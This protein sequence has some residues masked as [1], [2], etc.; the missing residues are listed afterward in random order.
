MRTLALAAFSA[1]FA[2]TALDAARGDVVT[3]NTVKD[4]TLFESA[5]GAKADGGWFSFY[6]GR[7]GTNSTTPI[8]R[9]LIAFDVAGAVPAGST[10]TNVTLKLYMSKTTSGAKPV[11]LYRL[12]TDWSEGTTTGQSGQGGNSQPGDVTWIHTN[13][14]NSFWTTPGGDFVSTISATQ[15][16]AGGGFYTWGSTPQMVADVQGWLDAPA[17]SFGWLLRSVETVGQKSA[18][19]FEARQSTNPLW[20]PALQI[21][22][23]PPAPTV[24]CTPKVDSAGCVP[25]IGYSGTPDANAGSGF[26]ITLGNTLNQ[27]SGLLF[28][29]THGATSAPFQGGTMCVNPPT[30]R[31]PIQNSGGNATPPDD[32]SGV[33]ALDFNVRIASGVDPALVAGATVWSQ[34]WSR[35]PV[36]PFTTNLSDALRF[37]IQP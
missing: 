15:S 23:T 2:T 4:S 33:F 24:Y 21:T 26:S 30:V 34:F 22:Y 8:R 28:Y 11:D 5:T 32:C 19:Q 16:V 18:K 12:T 20:K 29:G 25:S 36:D 37:L 17:S 13:Y 10:I 14:P 9:G 7:A 6:V 1:V 31:T 3:I 27:K 35:D